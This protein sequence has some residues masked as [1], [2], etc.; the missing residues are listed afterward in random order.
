MP[1]LGDPGHADIVHSLRTRVPS[2][3]K[4]NTPDAPRAIILVT[5]H[6]TTEQPTI[7]NAAKHELY[8]DYYGFPKEAYGLK[9]DA[10][11]SPDIAREVFD[12]LRGE[13]MSPVMDGERGN[14]SINLH[15]LQSWH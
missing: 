9:Y 8:Y 11:G 12:V 4:L 1:I 6:W 13:G 15:T 3:L 7:S 14:D 2:I 10:L 5:A